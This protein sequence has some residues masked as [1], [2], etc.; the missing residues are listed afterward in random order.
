MKFFLNNNDGLR[1]QINIYN[2]L[3]D[4]FKSSLNIYDVNK[5]HNF[6]QFIQKKFFFFF[7]TSIFLNNFIKI[8]Y[9]YFQKVLLDYLKVT[10]KT[11]FTKGN[12]DYE[13]NLQNHSIITPSGNFNDMHIKSIKT[14]FEDIPIRKGFISNIKFF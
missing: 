3:I 10:P 12:V 9:N 14:V 1:L 5:S 2:N 13:L 6:S 8:N 4:K 11:R 7:Y